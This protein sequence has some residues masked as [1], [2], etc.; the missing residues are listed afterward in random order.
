MPK[1]NPA[2]AALSLRDAEDR[3]VLLESLWKESPAVLVF[4]RH[5]G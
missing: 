3:P 2:L 1:I 5:Y 4:I